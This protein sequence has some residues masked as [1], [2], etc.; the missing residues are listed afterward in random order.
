MRQAETG[1]ETVSR[2]VDRLMERMM[3]GRW[4]LNGDTVTDAEMAE[5]PFM[6]R[7]KVRLPTAM[8]LYPLYAREQL[9]IASHGIHDLCFGTLVGVKE[10]LANRHTGRVTAYE[11]VEEG[12]HRVGALMARTTVVTVSATPSRRWRWW[13]ARKQ[14][15]TVSQREKWEDTGW[16]VWRER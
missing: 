2:E 7:G 10:F 11:E 16:R 1:G 4:V 5:E 14:Q 3:S 12:G 13:P 6:K 15:P 8:E 9:W